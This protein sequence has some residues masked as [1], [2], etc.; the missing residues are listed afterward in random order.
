MKELIKKYMYLAKC[1]KGKN[2]KIYCAYIM[3]IKNIR[4]HGLDVNKLVLA[5]ISR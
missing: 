3:R 1:H 5:R 2:Q 4:L